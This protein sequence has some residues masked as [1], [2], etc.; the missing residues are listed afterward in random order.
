MSKKG[1]QK[2]GSGDPGGKRKNSEMA[3]Y[4]AKHNIR[5]HTFR[6]PITNAIRAIGAYPGMSGK[7]RS[8]EA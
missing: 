4:M 5:R 6:D 7:A 3:S 2:T 8:V 1:A